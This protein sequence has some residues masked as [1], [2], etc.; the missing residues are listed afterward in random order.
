MA[1]RSVGACVTFVF[2]LATLVLMPDPAFAQSS[3]NGG[4]T[5]W[6]ITATALVLFMTLPGLALFYGGLVRSKNVLSAL[7]H[8]FAICSLMSVLWLIVGY[9]IAF[10]D[11]G[12]AN[13]WTGG[14]AKSFLAGVGTG[15]LSGDIPENVF[16]MFQM[17][18]A[19]ITPGLIVGAYV[20]R[21]KFSAVLWFSGLW[22][23]FVY[24]PS[25]HWIWGGGFLSD[26]GWMGESFKGIG[27]MDFAGGLVVHANAGIAA[28]VIAASLGSRIG[29]PNEL[30]PPHNPGLVMIG[31]AMLWVGW[32]GFNAGSA[33][34]ANGNAGMAMTVTHIS[35][36]AACLTWVA[37]EWVKFGKPSLVGIAT[38]AIAGLA[39]ITP[40][41]GFV[42]PVAGLVYGV[43][44]AFVC[45]FAIGIVKR[46]WKIDDSLDV[47][48]VHGVGGMLGILLTSFFADP[49]LGGLGLAEGSS[50]G[51]A[52][53]VQ[54]VAT[55]ITVVWAGIASYVI[56]KVVTATVGLRVTPEDEVEG[57][58]VTTHGE[59]S[60]DL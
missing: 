9:S 55:V 57:L 13:G 54:A 56:V 19:I 1:G 42:G 5:A 35:A 6:I 41:S 39:T 29:F 52:F 36:S 16:F 27:V 14:F 30:R 40:G 34:A 51:K 28:L 3:L 43:V 2:I 59:R 53:A 37:I 26:F 23:L 33:L 15:T 12:A 25:T 60:Y 48:A 47:F 8:C 21:I 11:G 50:M 24:A 18:F 10:G 58:D 7:M 38:G 46:M 17:T 44:A 45:Y 32:Y 20:E 31:A 4:N 49:S 22:L